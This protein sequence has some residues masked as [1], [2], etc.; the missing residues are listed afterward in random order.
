[1]IRLDNSAIIFAVA[2]QKPRVISR[3]FLEA[4]G[5]KLTVSGNSVVNHCVLVNLSLAIC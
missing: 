3:Q 1:M 5:I 2:R 4:R